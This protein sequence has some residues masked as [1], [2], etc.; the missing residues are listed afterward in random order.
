MYRKVCYVQ[1]LY[2]KEP[3]IFTCWIVPKSSLIQKDIIIKY[4]FLQMTRL[5]YRCTL[6]QLG[7]STQG[8]GLPDVIKEEKKRGK[9]KKKAV[10]LARRNKTSLWYSCFLY[11]NN[12]KVKQF[13][14]TLTETKCDIF[15]VEVPINSYYCVPS[16]SSKTSLG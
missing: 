14:T 2:F 9:K 7:G 13:K 6:R 11:T 12:N 4:F 5:K 16:T 15:S 1:S 8:R 10:I 3:I